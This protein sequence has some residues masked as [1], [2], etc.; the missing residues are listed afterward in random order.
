MFEQWPILRSGHIHAEQREEEEEEKKNAEQRKG[1]YWN[2][3]RK[4]SVR[5]S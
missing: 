3:Q 1:I 4:Y 5:S 2:I